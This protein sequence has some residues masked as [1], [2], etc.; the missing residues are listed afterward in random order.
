MM[1]D[2]QGRQI[3]I[4]GTSDGSDEKYNYQADR[5]L[6]PYNVVLLW[7]SYSKEALIKRVRRLSKAGWKLEHYH[8]ELGAVLIR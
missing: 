3:R 1:Y 4:A 2:E 5:N 8:G 6:D 7:R